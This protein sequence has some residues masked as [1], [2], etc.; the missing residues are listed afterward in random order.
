VGRF[1]G[2]P[3]AATVAKK[4]GKTAAMM[5]VANEEFAQS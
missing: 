3:L 1:P 2:R 5:V 4:M